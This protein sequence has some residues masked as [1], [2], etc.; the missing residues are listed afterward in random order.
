[1]LGPQISKASRNVY[2]E[3]YGSLMHRFDS[4][5]KLIQKK[6]AIE[7][8]IVQQSC[9]FLRAM[10]DPTTAIGTYF[11][12]NHTIPEGFFQPRKL[13][14]GLKGGRVSLM[15]LTASFSLDSAYQLRICD[16][17]R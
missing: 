14:S 10:K 7:Q 17:N 4:K 16:F 2:A 15:A 11:Q 8:I 6:Y 9:R 13:R 1:M 3:T 5:L 12:S